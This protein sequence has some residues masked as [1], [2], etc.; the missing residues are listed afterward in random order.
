MSELGI[1]TLGFAVTLLI[2]CVT[3]VMT[4]NNAGK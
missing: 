1:F 3:D 2:I 4:T